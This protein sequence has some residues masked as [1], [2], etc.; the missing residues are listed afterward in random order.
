[1][2]EDRKHTFGWIVLDFDAGRWWPV[3]ET[4]RRTRR[5][6]QAAYATSSAHGATNGYADMR[7]AGWVRCVRF[8]SHYTE[9]KP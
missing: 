4:Y 6:S 9:P 1:M 8:W 2:S 5:E 7:K 3:Y